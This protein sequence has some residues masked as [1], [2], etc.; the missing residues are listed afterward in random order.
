M[1]YK[2]NTRARWTWNESEC[3]CD[4]RSELRDLLHN[5]TEL[6]MKLRPLYKWWVA[7]LTM[8]FMPNQAIPFIAPASVHRTHCDH[9]IWLSL[10]ART[11]LHCSMRS[12]SKGLEAM[13][14]TKNAFK[15]LLCPWLC[16]PLL[17]AGLLPSS[18]RS[19]L[20]SPLLRTRHDVKLLTSGTTISCNHINATLM[21]W[22]QEFAL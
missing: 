21:L 11:G 1:L 18:V 2:K 22:M 12:A 4:K 10:V 20:S 17:D 9:K 14:N 19:V 6:L 5:T 13:A 15:I 8:M 3:K 7:F 16:H